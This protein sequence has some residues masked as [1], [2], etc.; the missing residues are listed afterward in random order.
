VRNV[1]RRC[2]TAGQPSA[3]VGSRGPRPQDR[4]ATLHYRSGAWSSGGVRFAG[5]SRD[6]P[7]PR[8]WWGKLQ[9]GVNTR[10]ASA[11]RRSTGRGASS[12]SA[13]EGRVNGLSKGARLRS[14]RSGR[15]VGESGDVCGRR[16]RRAGQL[17]RWSDGLGESG[18][19]RPFQAVAIVG[20]VPPPRLLAERAT[21]SL[22]TSMRLRAGTRSRSNP[23]GSNGRRR[24]GTALREGKALQGEPQ[25]RRGMKQGRGASGQ[26]S[27]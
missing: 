6:R 10:R 25:G 16:V 13:G 20:L 14:G 4:S 21:E 26:A 22:T 11:R 27:S 5:H 17:V 23:Q 7:D 18:K 9:K 24:G 19:V 15:V 12:G 3:T 8:I 1:R 2:A